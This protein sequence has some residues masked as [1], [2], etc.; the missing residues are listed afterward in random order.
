MID[1]KTFWRRAFVLAA[2]LSAASAPARAESTAPAVAAGYSHTC[3]VK[4]DHTLWCWGNNA[5]GQLG[6]GTT[7]SRPAPVQVTA[8]GASVAEVSV[9]D[10]YTCAR[11]LDHTLWCWGNNTSGQL[12]N[13]TTADSSTPVQVTALGTN[14]AEASA[15]DLFACARLTDGS[16]ACWGSGP[17]GDGTSTPSLSPV[18]V[19]ALGTSVAEIS[20]GDGTVC[21][22][23]T[24]GTLWCWGFNAFGAVGDGT[25]TDRFSPT[26]VTTLG[27]T[28]ATVSVGDIFACAARTDG[29]VWCWGTNDHGELGDG[30]T[31]SHLLPAVVGAL[32]PGAG[33]VAA[34]G[35][36]ACAR[37][38][39][40]ALYCWGWNGA[41]ELGD[42]T[43]T[44][45]HVPV[46]V[47]GLSNS[48]SQV[49]AAVNQ[50][51]CAA[52][53]DGSVWCWGDNAFGQVGDGTSVRRAVPV[54]VLAPLQP[55]SV[56]GLTGWLRAVLFLLLAAVA[57]MSLWRRAPVLAALIV[58]VLVGG[59]LAGC[60]DGPP[61]AA[62]PE[63]SQP[64][65]P[66]LGSIQIGLQVP[67]SFQIA[68][69]TYQIQRGAFIQNGALDVSKGATVSAV[70]A[71]LPVGTGYQLTMSASDPTHQLTGCS[72]TATFDVTAGGTTPVPIAIQCHV[73]PPPAV[74]IP[75]PAVL[76][77]AVALLAAG[78]RAADAAA[79]K[80]RR[81][82]KDGTGRRAGRGAGCSAPAPRSRRSCPG[83]R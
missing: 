9:G 3:A 34:N 55:P 56:P 44:E 62:A 25:T 52:L 6:D 66:S 77:L 63:P 20:T 57:A 59:S 7:T 36:H 41:G 53:A 67:P 58:A 82:A 64:T 28:V 27:A 78:W 22:R 14:V 83:S 47:S 33:P 4:A 18:P 21:A 38:D 32:P 39:S 11:K 72:G 69:F 70:I 71:G 5:S 24:D 75:L 65:E 46:A 68:A 79:V 2:L 81:G 54:R 23:R 40:G 13:G 50:N 74:P 12:G 10:L 48:A 43:T 60:A 1:P 8:L 42:G 37:V 61:R 73:T 15:G 30:T 31:T 29:S 17:L 45:R 35:R 19:A 49:S 80:R 51:S 26:Q 76:S 16:A